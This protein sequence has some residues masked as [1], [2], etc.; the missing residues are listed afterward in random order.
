MSFAHFFIEKRPG[1]FFFALFREEHLVGRAHDTRR[2]TKRNCCRSGKGRFAACSGRK[3]TGI[4]F[5]LH[6][7]SSSCNSSFFFYIV[8]RPVDST[9]PDQQLVSFWRRPEGAF[10]PILFYKTPRGRYFGIVLWNAP[11]G[12]Y[13]VLYGIRIFSTYPSG[14]LSG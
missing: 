9:R 6:I 2:C 13:S 7:Y 11:G 1:A 10:C 12:V 14:L 4:F 5:S 8:S 3:S